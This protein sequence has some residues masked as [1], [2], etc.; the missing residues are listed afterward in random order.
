M[1]KA[2]R[3]YKP[4]CSEIL[5]ERLRLGDPVMYGRMILIS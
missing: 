2:G 5:E 1:G 3:K 4:F